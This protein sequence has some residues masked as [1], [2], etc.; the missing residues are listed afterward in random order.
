M[1]LGFSLCQTN[2]AAVSDIHQNLPFCTVYVTKTS[3]LGT[4]ICLKYVRFIY[5][6]KQQQIR[7]VYIFVLA[8]RVL[9]TI[10]SSKR[11]L[12]LCP[13]PSPNFSPFFFGGGGGGSWIGLREGLILFPT[14]RLLEFC[15]FR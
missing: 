5:I 1:L 4:G 7:T 12:Y 2:F 6:Y 3:I 13:P 9:E 8:L 15:M 11:S 14:C 10:I